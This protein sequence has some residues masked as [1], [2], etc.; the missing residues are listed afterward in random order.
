MV[1]AP[2]DVVGERRIADRLRPVEQQVVVIEDVLRLLGF[3]IGREQL[4][5]LLLPAG[6]PGKMVPEHVVERQL[7]H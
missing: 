4:A 7:R 2:A 5:Q 1:E 3:D 6:A